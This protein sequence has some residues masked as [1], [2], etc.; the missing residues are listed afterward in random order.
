MGMEYVEIEV[1]IVKETDMA[2]LVSDGKQEMWLPK[3]QI[4]E[5]GFLDEGEVEIITIPE[6]LAEKNNLC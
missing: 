5:S 3:S 4:D 2:Y 1:E 6:W